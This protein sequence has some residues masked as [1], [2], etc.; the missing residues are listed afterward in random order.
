MLTFVF[1]GFYNVSANFARAVRRIFQPV[2]K[3]ALMDLNS[4]SG[5]LEVKWR[6][7]LEEHGHRIYQAGSSF[8]VIRSRNG[9]K[10]RFLWLLLIGEQQIRRLNKSEQVEIQHYLKQAKKER[11]HAYLVVGF[12]RAPRRIVV[13]PADAALKA[14]RVRSDKGGIAWSN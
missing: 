10:A 13:L 12:R 5:C 3:I 6:N 2:C 4:V 14:R 8:N 1:C 9:D 7:Y 11:E